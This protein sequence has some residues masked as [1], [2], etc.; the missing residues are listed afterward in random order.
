MP[1]L[2]HMTWSNILIILAMPLPNG[3]SLILPMEPQMVWGG[4]A[5]ERAAVS[6]IKWNSRLASLKR[7]L[8]FTM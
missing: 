2:I 1:L 7:S 5:G 6:S 8:N 4:N 3:T